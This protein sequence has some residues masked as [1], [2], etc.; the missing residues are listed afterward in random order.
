MTRPAPVMRVRSWAAVIDHARGIVN[1]SEI[2]MTL[3]RLFYK[4]VAAQ[5]I[6]NTTSAY[7]Q[8]SKHT[9]EGRRSITFPPL[10]DNP[11][12]EDIDRD[13][14]VRADWWHMVRRLALTSEPV[15]AEARQIAKVGAWLAQP[16]VTERVDAALAV[17]ER[18]TIQ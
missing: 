5:H 4:L 11:S 9:A 15:V 17:A 18:T 13:F 2:R 10:V 14:I 1:R 8:L 3:R 6:P 12:G 16:D 7:N